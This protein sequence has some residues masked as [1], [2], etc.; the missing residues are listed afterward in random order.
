MSFPD[1]N[2]LVYLHML[3]KHGSATKVAQEMNIT[4]PGVSAA[5]RRLRAVLQDPVMVRSGGRLVPTAKALDAYSRLAPSLEMWE[6]LADGDVLFDP[7]RT[8]RNYTLLASD[9]IQF[10]LLPEIAR[11]LSRHAPGASLRVIPPN[12]YRR[13]QVVVEREAD[14]AIGYF[15][16]APEN[17]R[18]R[19]LF[20]EQM[21]CVIRQGHPAAESF[22]RGAFERFGHIGVISVAQGAYQTAM[23]K[24]LTEQGVHR[25]VS[26]I[27]PNYLT[28]PQILLATDYIGILPAS[29]GR[30]LAQSTRFLVR[31]VPVSLP[32]L[33]VSIFFHGSAQNEP[34]NQWFRNLVVSVVARCEAISAIP[35]PP[36]NDP[37]VAAVR[38]ARRRS[39]RR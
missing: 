24:R 1:L 16:E 27:V 8:T 13:L 38:E 15:H 31:A 39:R 7:S 29:L 10:L 25:T 19:R 35:A 5:L 33:D 18:A 21:V 26:I 3:I 11:E 14:F 28:V 20:E 37:P 22:D 34:S 30:S 9:Y 6:R 4:Q 32:P 36:E 2:L 17:L 23:E 12:P